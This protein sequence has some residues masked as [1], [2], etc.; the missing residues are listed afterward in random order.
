[1]V[2]GGDAEEIVLVGLVMVSVF[3]N[4]CKFQVSVGKEYGFRGARGAGGKIEG[5]LIKEI[6]GNM[7]MRR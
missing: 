5:S 7:G 6:Y 1:M 4:A 2:E 3:V